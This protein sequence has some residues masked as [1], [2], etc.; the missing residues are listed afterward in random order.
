MLQ[1]VECQLRLIGLFIVL[2]VLVAISSCFGAKHEEAGRDRNLD[3][4]PFQLYNR[5]NLL[6]EVGVLEQLWGYMYA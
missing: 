4:V 6:K 5:K 3:C 2:Q 1:G